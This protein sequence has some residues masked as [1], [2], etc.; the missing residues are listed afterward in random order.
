MVLKGIRRSNYD[1]SFRRSVKQIIA[2]KLDVGISVKEVGE[3][4]EKY[5]EDTGEMPSE[6]FLESL[7][8]AMLSAELTDSNS[9][10][11]RRDDYPILSASQELR[12]TT[13]RGEYYE[14]ELIAEEVEATYSKYAEPYVYSFDDSDDVL[15]ESNLYKEINESMPVTIIQPATRDASPKVTDKRI[16][17]RKIWADEVKKRDKYRCQKPQC[18]SRNGIMHAHHILNY[19]D[20]PESRF[21]VANGI[22]LC[23]RCHTEFHLIYGKKYTN[24]EQIREFFVS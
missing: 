11:M 7:A 6:V 2:D 17:L 23:E 13:Q 5:F 22:T 19:A 4:V 3:M 24:S 15:T 12:R 10:K 16:Y 14:V 21:E 9:G 8:D 1:I 18:Q 20:Y